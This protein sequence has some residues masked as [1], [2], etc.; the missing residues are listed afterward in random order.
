[1]GALAVGPGIDI[2]IC[3]KMCI[4]CWVILTR[5]NVNE[6]KVRVTR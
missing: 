4:F 6:D 3:W 5:Q 2:A 1:M